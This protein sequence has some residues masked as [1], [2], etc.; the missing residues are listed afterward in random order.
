[1][2]QWNNFA[3]EKP[4][5]ARLQWCSYH[6]PLISYMT[7]DNPISGTD[8]FIFFNIFILRLLTYIPTAIIILKLFKNRHAWTEWIASSCF[9]CSHLWSEIPSHFYDDITIAAVRILMKTNQ[10][11]KIVYE[12]DID[13]LF[14]RRKEKKGIF[15]AVTYRQ[16]IYLNGWIH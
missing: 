14:P 4:T 10:D 15:T 11:R 2:I 3:L 5:N 7:W 9:L 6:S 8:T 16:W 13:L 12:L 1:M